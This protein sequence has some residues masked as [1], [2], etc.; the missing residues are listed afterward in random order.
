MSYLTKNSID[1][2]FKTKV[3]DYRYSANLE[4][5]SYSEEE[6]VFAGLMDK[7]ISDNTKRAIKTDLK[8][9]LTWFEQENGENFKIS[10]IISRD[11]SDYKKFCLGKY[12]PQTTNRRLNTLRSFL[13][14]AFSH[15]SIS[16]PLHLDIKLVP[17]NP[18]SPKGLS[19]KELRA[20]LRE[21]E[22]RNKPRDILIVELLCGAGL[23][24]SEL[25]NLRVEDV[26]LKDRS[27]YLSIKNSKGNKSRKVPLNVRIR[28]H[29]ESF[30]A[31][32]EGKIFLGQ[33][34]PIT[35]IAVNKLLETYTK[36]IGIKCSPH[37]LRHTFAYNYLKCNPGEIVSLSQI[38]GHSNLNTTA[39]YTQ[40]RLEDLQEKVEE[41]DY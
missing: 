2:I 23:R 20:L 8:H 19:K 41:V 35:T 31:D 3:V 28:K 38:L 26:H 33:R 11:L 32:K 16:K 29:L 40:N 34:G 24:V 17:L 9:F 39:I 4:L 27:G 1:N 6:K 25:V 37:T 30:I 10:N 15:D 21:V 5:T 22:H 13:K 36:R 18:L 12:A 14:R 7:D